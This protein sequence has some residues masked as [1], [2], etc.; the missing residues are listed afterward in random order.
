MTDE[1]DLVEMEALAAKV[2]GFLHGASA[3]LS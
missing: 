3:A 2:T 1:L